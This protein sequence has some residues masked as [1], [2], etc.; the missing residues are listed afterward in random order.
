MSRFW[1]NLGSKIS[2]QYSVTSQA[3]GIYHGV[4]EQ[5]LDLH[6]WVLATATNLQQ[7]LTFGQ[8]ILIFLGLCNWGPVT[9]RQQ[10]QQSQ[11]AELNRLQQGSRSDV[12]QLFHVS[13]LQHT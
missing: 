10:S 13:L 5:S 8:V 9:T 7:P 3:T 6:N 4:I 11:C 1:T 2:R 12:L